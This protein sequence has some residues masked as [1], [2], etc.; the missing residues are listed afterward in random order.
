MKNHSSYV[1]FAKD[2]HCKWSAKFAHCKQEC[3]TMQTI[4]L[5]TKTSQHSSSIFSSTKQ[6]QAHKQSINNKTFAC[7]EIVIVLQKAKQLQW[8][9]KKPILQ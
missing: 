7:L 1:W 8:Y 4:K 2:K 3:K 5:P 9:A 6:L